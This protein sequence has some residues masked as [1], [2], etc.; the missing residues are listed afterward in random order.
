MTFI[1]SPYL[2]LF[3]F[4]LIFILSLFCFTKETVSGSFSYK[5]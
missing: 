3:Y 4:L 1:S 2:F 5:T